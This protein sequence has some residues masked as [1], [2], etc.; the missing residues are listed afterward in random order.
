MR[1]FWR[2]L[3]PAFILGGIAL[4]AGYFGPMLLKGGANPD[5]LLAVFI[6]GPLGFVFGLGWGVWKESR[7]AAKRVD[8][9]AAERSDDRRL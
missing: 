6:T 8:L 9:K 7:R 3:R 1:N 2:I 4:A 5:P